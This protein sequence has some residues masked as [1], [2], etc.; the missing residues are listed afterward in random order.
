MKKVVI[1]CDPGIDDALALILAIKSPAL[2]VRGITTT[3]GNTTLKNATNNVLKLLSLL[4]TYDIQ[5]YKG[6]ETSLDGNFY[7]SEEVHGK[8]GLE[9]LENINPPNIN[10][11]KNAIKFF[12]SFLKKN[13]VNN[14]IISLGP[15]TNIATLIIK[16]PELIKYVNELYIMGGTI[17]VPGNITPESEFNIFCD[18]K[19]AEIVF[20]S[21]ISNIT[22]I[23]LDVTRKT[24]FT[25]KHLDI[26][27]ES[28]MKN[29]KLKRFLIKTIQF[30]QNYCI[31][32]NN[33]EGCPLHDPL[34][35]GE[36]INAYFTK[37]VFLELRVIEDR[38]DMKYIN[39]TLKLTPGKIITKENYPHLFY[40][41]RK[42][43]K[44]CLDVKYK[45]FIKF[46]IETLLS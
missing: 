28:P 25:K 8:N 21:P 24:L 30:Y 16:H 40:D 41:S 17:N 23:P 20:S 9:G 35:V 15:L 19:A 39:D 11:G 36:A 33:L 42:K 14:C 7:G 34:A 44:V 32:N 18:P 3:A 13:K 12:K 2:D 10:V 31:K 6:A 43:I 37:K 5:L 22:L 4:E 27:K 45:K 26:I 1:D 38:T 29:Q 46:F